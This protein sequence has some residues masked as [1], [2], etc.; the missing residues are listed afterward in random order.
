MGRALRIRLTLGGSA[1]AWAL[2]RN[3]AGLGEGLELLAPALLFA[4]PL[5][6]GRYV[7]EDLLDQLS[8]ARAVPPPRR[9]VHRTP[10]PRG[11]RRRVLSGGLLLAA[12]LAHRP[13]PAL[14]IPH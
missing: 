8:L 13:P 6:M 10:R 4:L 5:L 1:M 11:A 7:G 12:N 3:V 14:R 9:H 2:A